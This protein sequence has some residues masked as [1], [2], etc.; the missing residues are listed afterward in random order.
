MMECEPVEVM[1]DGWSEWIHPLSPYLLQCCDCRL[2]HKIE[3]QIVPRD[4]SSHELNPGERE[5][6]V[7]I[8]RARR[9]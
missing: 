2:V 4:A 5:D 1:E 7:I 8:F 3:F 9:A 6:A